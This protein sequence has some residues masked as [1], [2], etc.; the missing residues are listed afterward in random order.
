MKKL[1][2]KTLSAMLRVLTFT[3]YPDQTF[4]LDIHFLFRPIEVNLGQSASALLSL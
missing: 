3:A 1:S 2:R 4:D